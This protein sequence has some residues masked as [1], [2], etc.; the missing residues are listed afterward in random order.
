L[1]DLLKGLK[2][3]L[4]FENALCKTPA[5]QELLAKHIARHTEE[6]KEQLKQEHQ[7]ELAEKIAET[8]AE[9]DR[10][11]VEKE[12][13]TTRQHILRVL[14]KRFGMIAEDVTAQLQAVQ[15]QQQLNVLLDVALECADLAVFRSALPR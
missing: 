3:S 1:L 5:V 2:M 11:L 8:I 10:A 7:R 6:L 9:K 4:T 12:H 13:E 14:S 15:D